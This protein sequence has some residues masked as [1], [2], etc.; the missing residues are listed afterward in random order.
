MSY[1]TNGDDNLFTIFSYLM[2]RLYY[3]ESRDDSLKFL[4]Y[5]EQSTMYQLVDIK[6]SSSNTGQFEIIVSFFKTSTEHMAQQEPV[7]FGVVTK[8]PK[9]AFTSTLF[10]QDMMAFEYESNEFKNMPFAEDENIA[11]FSNKFDAPKTKPKIG[12]IPAM[13]NMSFKHRAST[14]KND[15]DLYHDYQQAMFETNSLVVNAVGEIT[16]KP[17]S[18]VTIAVDRSSKD[19]NGNRTEDLNNL[20]TRYKAF[21]GPWFASKVRHIIE[22]NRGPEGNGSYRQNVVLFRNFINEAQQE[23]IED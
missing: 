22:P 13:Q 12:N 6:N 23:K 4:V 8:H 1:I 20:K 10:T 18:I 14:W 11:Y 17:G 19:L 7:N 5:N 21:E 15:I 2:R 9:S 16:R 3:F